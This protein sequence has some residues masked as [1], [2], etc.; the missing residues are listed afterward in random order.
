MSSLDRAAQLVEVLAAAGIP[1]TVDPA[2][3]VPPVVLVPPPRR[4]YDLAV[5]FTAEWS[6]VA[7]T[8]PPGGV[9]AWR[10]LDDLVDAAAAALPVERAEPSAYQLAPDGPPHPAYLLTIREA[11]GDATY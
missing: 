9:G 5:G 6:L 1:A 3:A 7:L 10:D 2:A 11:I 4:V 8:S